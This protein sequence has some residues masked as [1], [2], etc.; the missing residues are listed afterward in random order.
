MTSG[1]QEGR[2]VEARISVAE[3]PGRDFTHYETGLSPLGTDRGE[4]AR[5]VHDACQRKTALNLGIAYSPDLDRMCSTCVFR[6]ANPGVYLH[7]DGR[8]NICHAFEH[9]FAA[10]ERTGSLARERE[11][12]L[13]PAET[14]GADLDV[15]VAFS[16]GKDSSATLA[17]VSRERGLR[18]HAVLVDNG[19]IPSFVVENCRRMCRRAGAVFVRLSF[20]LGPVVSRA[21]AEP[22][23]TAYPC[24]HCSK[25]FKNEIAEYALSKG[26]RRVVMGRN[27]WAFL[28][29]RLSG[30]REIQTRTGAG[31]RFY[32]L[33]FL[34]RWTHGDL[35]SRLEAIGWD[36]R[37]EGIPGM[38]TNCL[39]PGI[40][41][42]RYETATGIRPDA[43]ILAHE[44]IA[45]FITRDQALAKLRQTGRAAGE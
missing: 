17:H 44:V 42:P 35:E 38:S 25:V 20:D 40:L 15:V 28:E 34:L 24:N 5:V 10:A 41:D 14:R 30:V 21:C 12:C 31:V 8:C 23:A 7:P 32:S 1:V 33:P 11:E 37:H 9:G 22:T 6:T 16:G 2:P 19:Y 27:F 13:D 43:A 18:T 36:R 29:P 3:I 4:Y 39:V 45:G 26:C